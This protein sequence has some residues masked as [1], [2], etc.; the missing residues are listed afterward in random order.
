MG[1]QSFSTKIKVPVTPEN[2]TKILECLEESFSKIATCEIDDDE[3]K[4]AKV[5]SFM[6]LFKAEGT[7]KL[8]EKNDSYTVN[9]SLDCAPSVNFWIQ[10]GIS[11]ALV[12]FAGIGILLFGVDIFLFFFGKS[13]LVKS[14]NYALKEAADEF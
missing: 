7:V 13:K 6:N 9:V 14:V 3:L 1:M 5:K 11:A 2:K 8:K 12:L 10:V 4:V